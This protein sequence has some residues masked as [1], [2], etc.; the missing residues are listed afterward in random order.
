MNTCCANKFPR[1]YEKEMTKK[2]I[3]NCQGGEEMKLFTL[4]MTFLVQF[5]FV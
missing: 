2:N 1:R 3:H 4:S 5:Y